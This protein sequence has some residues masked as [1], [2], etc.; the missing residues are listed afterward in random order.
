METTAARYTSGTP[1]PLERRNCD[2][3]RLGASDDPLPLS[4][5]CYRQL[6]D[7]LHFYPTE[8]AVA[9]YNL[10]RLQ[11]CG[12]PV[13]I[14]KAVH[15]GPSAAK[16]SSDDAS[17]LEPTISIAHGTRVMLN[18]N[19]WVDAGLVNGAM[20]TVDAICY[21]TGGPPDFLWQSW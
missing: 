7:A 15:S 21:C 8:Q 5:I 16:A 19:L 13:A 2:S 1:P 14:I 10:V 3:C 20:G 9:E 12:Q 6:K 18:S 11:S 17:G 4:Y